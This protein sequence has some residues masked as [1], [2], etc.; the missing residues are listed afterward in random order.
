M[1]RIN[2]NRIN[3]KVIL[4]IFLCSAVISTA[5]GYISLYKSS[6]LM[7][8]NAEKRLQLTA[9]KE[10]EYLSAVMARA[11]NAVSGLG[12][13][14]SASFDQVAAT[15]NSSNYFNEFGNNLEPILAEFTRMNKGAINS[16]FYLN[17]ELAN[18]Q[19]TFVYSI[20]S[21][22]T[23][24]V[25][26]GESISDSDTISSATVNGLQNSSSSEESQTAQ[27]GSVD[28]LASATVSEIQPDSDIADGNTIASIDTLI[29]M[30][31]ETIQQDNGRWSK[32]YV[33]KNLRTEMISFSKPVYQGDTLIGVVGTDLAFN[34]FRDMITKIHIYDSGYAFM[35]DKDY[36]FLVHPKYTSEDNL[37]TVDNGG[38][39]G[40]IS[41][42]DGKDS[43]VTDYTFIKEKSIMGYAKLTNGYM[44]A[45]TSP[46]KEVLKEISTLRLYIYVI[47]FGGLLIGILIA[48]YI[49]H[50]ITTPILKAVNFADILASGDL[51]TESLSVRTNDETG[52]L[53]K[54]LNNMQNNLKELIKKV[55]EVSNQVTS[56][57]EQMLTSSKEIGNS[58]EEVSKATQELSAGAVEQADEIV[59]ITNQ[60]DKLTEHID[61]LGRINDNSNQ[62]AEAMNVVA[63]EGQVKINSV[64]EQMDKIEKSI[65]EVARDLNQ[66][67]N[68]T[69]EIDLILNIINNIAK[70][71]NL[72][73]LNASIEAAR[74]GENGKGFSVVAGEIKDL[75][76][77]SSTSANKIRTLLAQIKNEAKSANQKMNEGT[78]T[79][80]DGKTVVTEANDSFKNIEKAIEVVSGGILETNEALKD[81]KKQAD[82]IVKSVTNITNIV[83]ESSAGNQEVA[84]LA[85]EQNTLIEELVNS[86]EKLTNTSRVLDNMISQFEV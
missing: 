54:A 16:Y 48:I 80:T 37:G 7:K 67:S 38:L 14:I 69:D 51:K 11:E 40:L 6:T 26:E 85:E 33:D 59:E 75:A 65:K 62:S 29:D 83:E 55:K 44:L 2:L 34:G 5:V 72:L 64:T 31:D 39:K 28:T 63:G 61:K 15:D 46:Q 35:M 66:L 13:A 70:Q 50:K 18:R 71:T 43:G 10:A 27:T 4:A 23:N 56:S 3:F 57:C 73:A 1:K 45:V 24:I 32:V 79:I 36:N 68:I 21:S 22:N 60:I 76:E 53:T 77:E 74:A 84:A 47:I 58:S 82:I 41:S 25:E 12:T 8:T 52:I 17:P 49:G 81:V 78:A 30:Y 19:Q 9:E 86:A 20:L 42:I